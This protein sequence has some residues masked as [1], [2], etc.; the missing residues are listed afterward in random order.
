MRGYGEDRFLK[1]GMREKEKSLKSIWYYST[2]I[3]KRWLVL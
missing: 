2:T 1:I 3:D